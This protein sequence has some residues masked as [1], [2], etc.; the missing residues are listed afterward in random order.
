M[1]LTLEEAA[2]AS[3]TAKDVYERMQGN[4]AHGRRN[5]APLPKGT[6]TVGELTILLRAFAV[7]SSQ[8]YPE[9]SDEKVLQSLLIRSAAVR[10]AGG[11]VS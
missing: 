4:G 10:E 6:I 2:E 3:M 9:M 11:A 5:S 8:I 7:M 1:F